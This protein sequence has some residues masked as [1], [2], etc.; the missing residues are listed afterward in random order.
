MIDYMI[1]SFNQHFWTSRH[2]L[3]SWTAAQRCY[4]SPIQI[5]QSNVLF[6]EDFVYSLLYEWGNIESIRMMGL[7]VMSLKLNSKI[8]TQYWTLSF[9]VIRK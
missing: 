1:V 6:Q 4:K 9:D 5:G 8:Y 7:W 3:V 2:S